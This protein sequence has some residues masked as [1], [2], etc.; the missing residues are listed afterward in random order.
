MDSVSSPSL[1]TK[2]SKTRRSPYNDFIRAE[3]ERLKVES[4]DVEYK[5]RFKQAARNWKT[6]TPEKVV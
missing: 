6:H 3:L 2:S 5:E 4:P 1:R